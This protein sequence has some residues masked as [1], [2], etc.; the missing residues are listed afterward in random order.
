MSV[1][2]I[3]VRGLY[4]SV[5]SSIN[6]D[7][8]DRPVA[9]LED[10]GACQWWCCIRQPDHNQF[11]ETD[12]ALPEKSDH[13]QQPWY[14]YGRRLACI[15]VRCRDQRLAFKANDAAT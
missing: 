12:D 7:R 11:P 3:L 9:R 8:T 1:T 4:A 15:V 5:Q 6:E 2:S 10:N 13:G 14:S